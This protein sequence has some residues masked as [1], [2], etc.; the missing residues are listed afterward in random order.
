MLLLNDRLGSFKGGWDA[1][2]PELAKRY[3]DSG[4]Q[5]M[6]AFIET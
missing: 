6:A 5:E 4:Y 1:A 2:R 3:R